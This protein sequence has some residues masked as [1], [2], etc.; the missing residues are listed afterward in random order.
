[1]K[2]IKEWNQLKKRPNI[3]SI[4]YIFFGDINRPLFPKN[5]AKHHSSGLITF[6][7]CA[8]A[9]LIFHSLLHNFAFSKVRVG[10]KCKTL[11]VYTFFI[12][13]DTAGRFGDKNQKLRKANK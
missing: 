11:I 12:V 7:F 5:I 8:P 6:C 4:D 3:Y 1:M 9:L 13:P 2:L 10:Y